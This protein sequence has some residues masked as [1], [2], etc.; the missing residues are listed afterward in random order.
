MIIFDTI[1]VSQIIKINFFY[2]QNIILETNIIMG[3][4]LQNGNGRRKTIRKREKSKNRKTRRK[5]I[6]K[7]KEGKM[8]K[9]RNKKFVSR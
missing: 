3:K 1:Y 6:Y 2:T 7:M 9:R 8:I 5:G 4:E